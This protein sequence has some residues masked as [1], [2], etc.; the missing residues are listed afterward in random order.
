MIIYTKLD[1]PSP[2]HVRMAYFIIAH[3]MVF[4]KQG[5]VGDN[6][7]HKVLVH[8]QKRERGLACWT[9]GGVIPVFMHM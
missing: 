5:Q 2:H 8:T 4:V 3:N 7:H 6:N 1:T 9:K